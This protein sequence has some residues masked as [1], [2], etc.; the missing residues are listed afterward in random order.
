MSSSVGLFSYIFAG[1]PLFFSVLYET[2]V[3]RILFALPIINSL[4]YLKNWKEN[5]FYE[6]MYVFTYMA[7]V[8]RFMHGK[9]LH[10][11]YSNAPVNNHSA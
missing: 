7:I 8:H 11:L 10:L 5:V 9:C 3:C 4:Q 2:L 1:R 6:Y